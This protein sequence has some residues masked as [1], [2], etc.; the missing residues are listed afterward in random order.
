MEEKSENIIK[1]GNLEV[2]S[3]GKWETKYFHLKADGL[4]F[5]KRKDSKNCKGNIMMIDAEECIQGKIIC[6]QSDL[7]SEH[8]VLRAKTE[9]EAR[10]WYHAWLDQKYGIASKKG[11]LLKM[12]PLKEQW[13]N[14]YCVLRNETMFFYRNDREGKI[15]ETINLSHLSLISPG[16]KEQYGKE[17]TWQAIEVKTN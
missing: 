9:V 10:G 6:F 8:Y 4:Y 3:A 17:N 14:E 16:T 13:Q 11:W 2:V 12:L 7:V 5:F 15:I 1:Q